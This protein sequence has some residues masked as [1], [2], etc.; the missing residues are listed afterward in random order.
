ML[1]IAIWMLSRIIVIFDAR[2]THV[3]E[4][5]AVGFVPEQSMLHLLEKAQKLLM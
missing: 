5:D 4:L 2:G 1:G 3:S